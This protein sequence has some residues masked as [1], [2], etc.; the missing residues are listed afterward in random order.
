MNQ[1]KKFWVSF[2]VIASV[3]V[4]ASAA[5]ALPLPNM[6]GVT[7]K[8]NDIV[9]GT[10]SVSVI[11]GDTI[12]VVV[13][14]TSNVNASDVRLS[15]TT[16]GA[17]VDAE[18]EVFVGDV[19]NGQTYTQ[20]LTLQVPYEL[21]DAQS[22]NL[23]LVVKMWN[24]QFSG[25]IYDTQL[26]V[27]RPSYNAEIMS[28]STVDSA[29]A[30]Q[31]VPVDVVVKNTGYNQL[32]D[33]YVTLKV[34]EL[35]LQRTAYFGD[36]VAIENKDNPDTA[37]GRIFLQIPS[38]AK[39]GTYTIEVLVENGDFSQTSTASL[40]ITNDF[41]SNVIAS[42]S[43]LTAAVGEDVTYTLEIVNPTNEIK[44]YTIVPQTISGVKMS[45][46][47]MVTVPAG[48]SRTVLL[49]AKATSEGNYNLSVNVFSGQELTGNVNLALNAAGGVSN[50]VVVLT[51]VL[52]IIFVALLVVL[53]VLVTKKP[54]K[55]EEFEESYY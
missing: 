4:L 26:R 48:S 14:F 8:V 34:P 31:L 12:P 43:E 51:I 3:L 22:G 2:L 5:S 19:E 17:K 20:S 1:Q 13:T 52:A 23:H 24:G 9:T 6:S 39:P 18:K 32:N 46:D 55:Q 37:S 11:A 7:L 41:E 28:F 49:N 21:Q 29:T 30:G 42:N 36:L 50:P 38:N 47:S 44:V 53:L 35:G 10:N 40:D 45:T 27:Q 15:I 54:K 16:E 25:N 33:L